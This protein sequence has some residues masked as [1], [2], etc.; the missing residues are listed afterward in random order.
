MQISTT[1]I[2]HI[3]IMNQSGKFKQ[4]KQKN[5]QIHR[6]REREKYVDIYI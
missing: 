3:K 1:N 4:A 2:N 6:E 5:E